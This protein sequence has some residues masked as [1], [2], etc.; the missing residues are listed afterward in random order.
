MNWKNYGT[1]WHIDHK[2]PD[3]KFHYESVEDEGFKMCWSLCNLQPLWATENRK[4][5]CKIL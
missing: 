4:K 2:K 1:D 5:G 3:C